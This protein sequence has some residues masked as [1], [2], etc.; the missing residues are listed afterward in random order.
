MI[1]KF[2]NISKIL[3]IIINQGVN[4]QIE[5]RRF[6]GF[7][8][9]KTRNHA[10]L[11]GYWNKA[12]NCLWDVQLL[13]YD[14]QFEYDKKYYTDKVLGYIE[15]PNNN[16]KI[17]LKLRGAVGWSKEKFFRDAK[18]YIREYNKINH[19]QGNLILL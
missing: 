4:I 9:Y 18:R 13:G 3:Y 19:I 2:V 11:L 7:Y 16:H 6:L 17:L 14:R 1:K 8:T 10:E 5:N 12:D 15:M